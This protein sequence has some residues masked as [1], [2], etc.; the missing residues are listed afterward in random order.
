M[1]NG[2]GRSISFQV[3]LTESAFL[4]RVIAFGWR[5][6][7]IRSV[8]KQIEWNARHRSKRGAEFIPLQPSETGGSRLFPHGGTFS[9]EAE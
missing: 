3:K 7:A 4:E 8:G 6:L 5:P 1:K 2:A 9:A